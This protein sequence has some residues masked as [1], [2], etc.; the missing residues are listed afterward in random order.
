MDPVRRIPEGAANVLVLHGA[1][2]GVI[3]LDKAKELHQLAMK[4]SRIEILPEA[5]HPFKDDPPI[6]AARMK[7]VADFLFR[8]Q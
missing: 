2:D 6:H 5:H 1:K 3:E 4:G 8:G 7:R